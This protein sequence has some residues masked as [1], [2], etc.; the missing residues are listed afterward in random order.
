MN[1]PVPSTSPPET[2]N[3]PSSELSSMSRSITVRPI[4][5]KR[6]ANAAPTTPWN[7]PSSMNG[8]RMNQFVAPTSFITATSRRR[9]KI[10]M[11]MVLRIS[12]AAESSSTPA[13]TAIPHF[14]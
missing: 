11:R 7:M 12:S 10:A 1:S 5:M 2:T 6:I 3:W 9:A 13:M 4:H 8:M 14:R